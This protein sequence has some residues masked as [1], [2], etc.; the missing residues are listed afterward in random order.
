M[1]KAMRRAS[2]R[3]KAVRA[4][5]DALV[6]Q[7]R[8][9]VFFTEL[10]VQDSLDGRFDMVALH[11]WL[12]LDRLNAAG[13]SDLADGLAAT[14]FIG[15]DEA[16]RDLGAGDIG[17]G[18]KIKAMREAF[19]GRAQAYTSA[20][21]E[22]GLAAAILRNVYRGD[23][24]HGTEARMIARYALASRARLAGADP[25]RGELAFADVGGVARHD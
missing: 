11:A 5:Y 8:R 3:T 6:F 2:A 18:R 12:V 4:L 10:G 20:E 19:N 21:G 17:M 9:P 23:E 25:C 22:A 24:R 16:L 14:I 15:F 7:S 13:L 1:L